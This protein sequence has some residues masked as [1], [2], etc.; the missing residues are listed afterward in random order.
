MNEQH[1][2]EN[3]KEFKAAQKL[4]EVLV[5]MQVPFI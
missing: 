1:L 5:E 2:N 4:K 3:S